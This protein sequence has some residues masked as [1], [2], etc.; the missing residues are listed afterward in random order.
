MEVDRELDPVSGKSS[1]TS[2]QERQKQEFMRNIDK[3]GKF[4]EDLGYCPYTG[5]NA[6]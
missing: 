1:R 6:E 4:N 5:V 2:Q 3:I